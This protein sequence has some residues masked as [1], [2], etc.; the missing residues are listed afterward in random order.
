[1]RSWETDRIGV[2]L[3]MMGI[4]RAGLAFNHRF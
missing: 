3:G 2:P 4:T 1:M